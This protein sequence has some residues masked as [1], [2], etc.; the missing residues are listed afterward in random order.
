[1]S[2]MTFRRPSSFK[3]GPVPE[4]GRRRELSPLGG[5]VIQS[6]VCIAGCQSRVYHLWGHRFWAGRVSLYAPPNP[7]LAP[8]SHMPPQRGCFSLGRMVLACSQDRVRCLSQS[9]SAAKMMWSVEVEANG[10]P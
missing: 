5:I 1:M 7:T 9:D 10:R 8:A 2:E 4:P 3:F 6:G